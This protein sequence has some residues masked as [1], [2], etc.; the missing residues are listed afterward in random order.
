[1]SLIFTASS[2][3][4]SAQHSSRLIGPLVHWLFPNLA[5]PRVEDIIFFIRK[6]AHVTE[7]A[8]FTLLVWRAIRKPV[9]NDPRPWSWPQAWLAIGIAFVYASSDEIHQRFVPNREGRFHDVLIDT[10]GAILGMVV[11]CLLMKFSRV[12]RA[13]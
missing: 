6:C 8:L 9:R 7:F 13:N 2:D 10:G 5:E 3:S 1:M 12:T 4:G 11:I